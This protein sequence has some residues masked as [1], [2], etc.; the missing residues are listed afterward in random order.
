MLLAAIC[1]GRTVKLARILPLST[2]LLA[3]SP[4]ASS[5][6]APAAKA[7]ADVSTSMPV[8]GEYVALSD[9]RY[10]QLDAVPGA[11]SQGQQAPDFE[12]PNHLGEKTR[13]SALLAEGPVVLMF[14][15]GFW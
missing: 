13:L 5:P 9:P 8:A 15:R 1:Y 14:Y 6:A 12:L 4:Q 10:G 2:V 11:P 7:E 3:C